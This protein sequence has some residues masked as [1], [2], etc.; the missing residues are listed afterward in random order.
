MFGWVLL[1]SFNGCHV[2]L[3]FLEMCCIF[4]WNFSTVPPTLC[5]LLC[6]SGV[7]MGMPH[8]LDSLATERH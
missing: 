4:F 2:H 5:A 7:K 3:L 8:F 1:I 6:I